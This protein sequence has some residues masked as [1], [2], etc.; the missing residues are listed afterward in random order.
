LRPARPTGWIRIGINAEKPILRDCNDL[1][2]GIAIPAH[3]LALYRNSLSSSI[4]RW[5]K[6]YFVDPMTYVFLRPRNIIMR[7]DGTG[8]KKSYER[9]CE[10]SPSARIFLDAEYTDADELNHSEARHFVDTMADMTFRIQVAGLQAE[11]QPR[12]RAHDSLERI[13]RHLGEEPSQSTVPSPT[14]LVSPYFYIPSLSDTSYQIW[15][16][17]INA[18]ERRV[19]E[20]DVNLPVCRALSI[21]EEVLN[22]APAITQLIQDLSQRHAA[23][24][25]VTQFEGTDPTLEKLEGL[26]SLISGISEGGTKLYSL[27]GSYLTA[28]Y[29]HFGLDGL[30]YGL[31]AGDSKKV[32][33][34]ATGGGAPNRYYDPRLHTFQSP[35]S[36]LDYYGDSVENASRFDCTCPI[37]EP[38]SSPLAGESQRENLTGHLSSMFKQTRRGRIRADWA[39]MRVHFLHVRSNELAHIGDTQLTTLGQEAAATLQAYDDAPLKLRTLKGVEILSSL[40]S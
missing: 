1:Y 24:L 19:S 32:D 38:V 33:S 12:P 14:F 30:S 10:Y 7:P 21:D 4:S 31:N 20:S 40:A 11:P 8:P 6:P 35:A 29:Y 34:H 17:S 18:F 28:S 5:D 22:D 15:L 25:W 3:V 39:D 26:K 2:D 16:R 36:M 27:Y 37:C 13:R 9:M 23:L